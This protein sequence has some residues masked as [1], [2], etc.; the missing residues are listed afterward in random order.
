MAKKF[1]NGQ[2]IYL[3]LQEKIVL[4][5]EKFGYD[6]DRGR[7]QRLDKSL[8]IAVPDTFAWANPTSLLSIIGG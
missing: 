8:F 5:R 4:E 3:I 7:F 2:A 1:L 6:L